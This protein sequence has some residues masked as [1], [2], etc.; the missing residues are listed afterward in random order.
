MENEFHEEY[1]QQW[2]KRKLQLLLEHDV[3]EGI[4]IVNKN[5]NKYEFNLEHDLFGYTVEQ[6]FEGLEDIN[7]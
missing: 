1:D 2:M 6:L 3:Q 4:L 5:T 7:T